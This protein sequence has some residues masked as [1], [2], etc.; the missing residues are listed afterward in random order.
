MRILKPGKS[1]HIFFLLHFPIQPALGL[2]VQVRNCNVILGLEINQIRCF[3]IS[4]QNLTRHF[5]NQC[6]YMVEEEGHKEN[7]VNSEHFWDIHVLMCQ[8]RCR[9]HQGMHQLREVYGLARCNGWDRTDRASEGE[10]SGL[11]HTQTLWFREFSS[12]KYIVNFQE[13]IFQV[14]LVFLTQ[15]WF[16]YKGE[17]LGKWEGFDCPFCKSHIYSV[18]IAGS[19]FF[20]LLYPMQGKITMKCG[21]KIGWLLYSYGH[22]CPCDSYPINCDRSCIFEKGL[23]RDDKF[24]YVSLAATTDLVTPLALS[25]LGEQGTVFPLTTVRLCTV[26]VEEGDGDSMDINKLALCDHVIDA[27]PK[28]ID[29]WQ[30]SFTIV[31]EGIDFVRVSGD[32]QGSSLGD[33]VFVSFV[34]VLQAFRSKIAFLVN[35]CASETDCKDVKFD[36]LRYFVSVIHPGQDLENSN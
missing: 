20:D 12:I 25:W 10:V 11:Y 15:T 24:T 33:A 8:L 13:K 3:I 22:R 35:F 19:L 5:Q 21:S 17:D 14:A 26:P 32:N 16:L 2:H 31:L 1:R 28:V 7:K 27:Q 36:I 29:T 30:A 34:E 6:V 18:S 4:F 9:S 23:L